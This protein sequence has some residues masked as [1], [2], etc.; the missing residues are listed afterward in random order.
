MASLTSGV[1]Y[2]YFLK[3]GDGSFYSSLPPLTLITNK[4]YFTNLYFLETSFQLPIGNVGSNY[5]IIVNLP[6]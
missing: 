5:S 4:N 3:T 2:V 6:K 1:N